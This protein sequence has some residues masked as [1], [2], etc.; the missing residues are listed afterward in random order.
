MTIRTP[1]VDLEITRVGAGLLIEV[2]LDYGAGC[3]AIIE[4]TA[5]QVAELKEI[6]SG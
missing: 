4:L 6:I 2:E 3:P 5:K 1:E